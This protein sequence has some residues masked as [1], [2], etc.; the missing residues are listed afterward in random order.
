LLTSYEALLEFCA[1]VY[2]V[3][4]EKMLIIIISTIVSKWN[5]K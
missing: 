3:V 1:Q 4:D 5:R 2:F